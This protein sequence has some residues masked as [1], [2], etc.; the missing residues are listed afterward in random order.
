MNAGHKTFMSYMT[1]MSDM[2]YYFDGLSLPALD[3]FIFLQLNQSL[4]FHISVYRL[5]LI[6]CF[7]SFK[8]KSHQLT[9]AGD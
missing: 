4:S 9:L 6:I 8:H 7:A 5:W 1:I 2:T 3:N